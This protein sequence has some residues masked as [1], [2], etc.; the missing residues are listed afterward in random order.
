MLGNGPVSLGGAAT[1]QGLCAAPV[2]HRKCLH[3]TPAQRILVQIFG[4]SWEVVE[5]VER[6]PHLTREP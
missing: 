2:T 4:A 5:L 1:R 6:D 3:V